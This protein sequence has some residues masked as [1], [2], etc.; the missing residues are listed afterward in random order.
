[1][2]FEPGVGRQSRCSDRHL[3]RRSW[4]PNQSSTGPMVKSKQTFDDYLIHDEKN[5]EFQEIKNRRHVMI[6]NEEFQEIKNRRHVMI[7]NEEF[8]EKIGRAHV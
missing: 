2:R 5:E 8:Q 6:K 3:E 7:K 1:M 4:C